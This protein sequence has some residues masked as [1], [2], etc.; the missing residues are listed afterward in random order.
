MKIFATALGVSA[1]VLACYGQ[2]EFTY[3][4]EGCVN[5][6]VLAAL[7]IGLMAAALPVFGEVSWQLG[8]RIKSVLIWVGFLFCA[9]TLFFGAAERVGAARAVPA[10]ERTA[11]R[12]AVSLAETSLSEAKA[13]LE[14]AEAD[15]RA[16]RKLPR[17]STKKVQGC[18]AGCLSRY[19]AAITSAKADVETATTKVT[20]KQTKAVTETTWKQP[21]WLLPLTIDYGSFIVCWFAGALFARQRK[22]EIETKVVTVPV[23]EQQPVAEPVNTR[24]VAARKGWKSRRKRLAVRQNGPKLRA[25]M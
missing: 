6:V 9:G 22:P 17:T 21:D 15:A 10:A 13:K 19:E 11:A 5:Y 23:A 24:S 4:L 16:A 2:F 18:D 3:G 12:S 20:S 8:M 25:V 14:R 1:G 7:L